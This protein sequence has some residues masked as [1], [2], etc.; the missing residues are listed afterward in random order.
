M[1]EQQIDQIAK[2]EM[3]FAEQEYTV[4]TLNTIVSRQDKEITLLKADLQMLKQQYLDMKDQLPGHSGESE[5]PPH[6]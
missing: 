6:Y 3:L 1:N 4:Q 5:K 2:L